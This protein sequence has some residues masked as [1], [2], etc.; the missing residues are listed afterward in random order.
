MAIGELKPEIHERLE[1]FLRR[2]GLRMTKQREVILRAAFGRNEHFTAEELWEQARKLDRR[3]SRATVYRTITLLREGGLLREIDLGRD[4]KVFDP[5]FL[6]HPHH[7]HLV[8]I[9][10]GK[11][12][13]F[14]DS[15]MRV[16]EEC[17]T[18][19]LGFRST[20]SS[21]RIEAMCDRLR[22][23]GVCPN[24]LQKRLGSMPQRPVVAEAGAVEVGG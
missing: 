12:I 19:R 8:C 14:E 9:D 2:R 10:C 24:L 4:Q 3:T 23:D 22:K 11:V 20:K 7:N 1:T 17:I 6:D 21:L 18:R 16:L 13:E 15:H 5:N